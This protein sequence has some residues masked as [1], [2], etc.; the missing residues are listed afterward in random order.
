MSLQFI[1]GS[2]GAGKS[3]YIYNRIIDKSLKNPRKKYI[4]I[5]PEQY[6]LQTQ[7]ELVRLHPDKVIMNIDVLSFNRLAYRVFEELGVETLDVLEETG[8]NLLIRKLA[9]EHP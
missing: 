4:I 9:R 5:V 7:K 2:S 1:I 3:T 8:K 6:T